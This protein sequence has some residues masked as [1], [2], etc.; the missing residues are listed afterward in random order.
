MEN[1]PVP[2]QEICPHWHFCLSLCQRKFGLS[3]RGYVNPLIII[4][5]D[6]CL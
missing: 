4:H 3:S 5:L 1:L 2:G 6:L